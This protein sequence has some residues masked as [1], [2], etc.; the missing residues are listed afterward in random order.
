MDYSVSIVF[1]DA[2]CEQTPIP[3]HFTQ[4][5]YY[6]LLIYLNYLE[7]KRED[8]SLEESVSHQ[9][10]VPWLYHPWPHLL[11]IIV[12]GYEESCATS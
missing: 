2:A 4:K 6:L 7:R 11:K 12:N 10:G 1:I 3:F 5:T 9:V 8:K